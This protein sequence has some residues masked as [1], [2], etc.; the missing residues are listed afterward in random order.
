MTEMDYDG[1]AED[2][3]VLAA[4]DALDGDDLRADILDVGVDAGE[5]YRGVTRFGTTWAEERRGESLDQLLAEEEPDQAPDLEWSDEDAPTDDGRV[6][7]R[8]AGRLVSAGWPGSDV[9]AIA[10]EVGVDGGGATAEEAAMHLTDD[11]PLHDLPLHD[12]RP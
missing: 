5:A 6:P 11:P 10:F 8:R 9:Q 12:S 7:R 4:A 2:D 3:G 1:F